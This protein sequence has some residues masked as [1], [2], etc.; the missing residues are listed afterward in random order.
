MENLDDST[1]T[2]VPLV[3]GTE[4]RHYRI[5]SRIGSG[6]MGEVYLAQD[7][8]LDRKL[9]LKFLPMH[10]CHDPELRSRFTREAQAAAKLNH[11]NIVTVYEV[12]EFN[13]RPFIAMEFVE[14]APLASSIMSRRLT[15]DQITDIIRQCAAA[16]VE[17]HDKGVIHRDIK[18]ANMVIDTGGRVRLVDFG[19]AAVLESDR[20]TRP[21]TTMGTF[22]YI[23]PE[24]ARGEACDGRA[25]LF[26]LGVV[27]YEMVTGSSPFAR[28]NS[29]ATL[30][31]VL[32]FDPPC[33]EFDGTL[34]P[35]SMWNILR[36]LIDKNVESRLRTARELLDELS[37]AAPD[38]P[39][40]TAI[41]SSIAILPFANMSE[42][43]S[44]EFF[45]DGIAE[46]IINDLTK[47][48]GL[49]VVA[50]T[51]AFA[52]K[53][54]NEDMRIIGRRLDVQFILEGSVR[55]VDKRVRVTAQLI[56]VT[57]GFHLW[58]ERYD[59]EITDI[60][61][62]QDD[63]VSNVVGKLLGILMPAEE[64]T[65]MHHVDIDAYEAYSRGRFHLRSRDAAGF[66]AAISCF[67]E[68]IAK[69]RDYARGFIGLADAYFLQYAYELAEPRD[70]IARARSYLLRALELDPNLAEAYATL[71]GILTFHDW[72]W[73]EAEAAFQESISLNPGYAVGHQWYGELLS[74][75]GR[76][77]E[78]EVRF[79]RAR[80]LDPLAD[81]IPIMHGV[82]VYIADRTHDAIAHF[83][84]AVAMG[85]KNENAYCWLAFAQLETGKSEAAI[86][87]L[88][89]ARHHSGNSVFSTVMFG[90]GCAL[91][92]DLSGLEQIVD[93][94]ELRSTRE[95]VSPALRSVLAFDRGDR[96]SAYRWLKE[97]IRCHNSEAMIMSVVPYYRQMRQ[98]DTVRT[99]LGI[100]GL[101]K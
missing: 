41:S 83:E 99:L 51:S 95:Y 98:D 26:S 6:A 42:D 100:L 39:G 5:L 90:H 7:T 89:K 84:E 86:R 63:I 22:A 21:Q 35:E 2:S 97:A 8:R 23:S 15:L 69:Q 33:P 1:R 3:N 10:S 71:G 53:G 57:D 75:C 27:W 62:I 88:Q 4:V 85:S 70:T 81:I 50:R 67:R 74:V 45:C 20:I 54:K 47:R 32:E 82:A 24:Q 29:P 11:P 46:D 37:T 78:A 91:A 96:E 72:A 61:S 80:E 55:K 28:D 25:D 44:Q 59:R 68:A 36:R 31:A 19:L 94:I 52:F 65:H 12:D 60:F 38:K 43:P 87:N 18:P 92:G 77:D 30:R 40:M 9:A 13:E 93:E 16:L 34:V 73:S 17:A 48:P 101:I 64:R 76:T 79:R 56:K 14:G 49:R 58:S 66:T